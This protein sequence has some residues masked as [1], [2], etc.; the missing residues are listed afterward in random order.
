MKTL[1]S[2]TILVILFAFGTNVLY[3][4]S[5][6]EIIVDANEALVKFQK[7]VPHATKIL[8]KSKGYV[9]FPDVNEAGFF[10]GGKYGEGVLV[11][12]D[13]IKSFHSITA[14]SIGM[15]MGMQNYALVIVFTTDKALKDFI[16]DEDDWESEIDKKLVIVEWTANDDDVD[17]VDYGTSMLGFAFDNTGM[18]G[19]LS[20]EGT[21]FETINPDD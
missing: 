14:A 15:Q 4:A 5:A 18:M 7:E 21:K 11:V 10:L 12:N 8:A 17:E 2:F 9:I 20:M 19:K 6:K 16:L 1:K 3:A 13:K